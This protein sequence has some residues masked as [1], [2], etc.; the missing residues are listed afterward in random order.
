MIVL[1]S[2]VCLVLVDDMPQTNKATMEPL[3]VER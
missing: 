3:F 2:D 1:K